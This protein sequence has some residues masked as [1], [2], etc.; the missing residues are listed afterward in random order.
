MDQQTYPTANPAADGANRLRA[1]ILASDD[2]RAAAYRSV[3]SFLRGI[4]ARAGSASFLVDEVAPRAV[5][6]LAQ[7]GHP[8]EAAA[9][10]SFLASFRPDRSSRALRFSHARQ[11]AQLR[12]DLANYVTR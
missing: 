7:E 9:L 6:T 4:R 10:L 5:R 11:L 2:T 3:C 1:W 12:Q 8:S